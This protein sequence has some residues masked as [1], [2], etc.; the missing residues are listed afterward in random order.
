[1]LLISHLFASKLMAIYLYNEFDEE[2]IIVA[3]ALGGLLPDL[4]DKPLGFLVLSGS[5]NY[6][7]IYFHGILAVLFIF[8]LS[9]ALIRSKYSRYG[10][11]TMGLGFGVLLHQIMDQMWN[12][13]RNWLYPFLGPYEFHHYPDFFEQSL[14]SELASPSEWLFLII[15]GAILI[16]LFRNR[17]KWINSLWTV[18]MGKLADTVL[19]WSPLVLL[20]LGIVLT[21]FSIVGGPLS[22]IYEGR[23]MLAVSA[24]CFVGS[25]IL[26]FR[27]PKPLPAK[28]DE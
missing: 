6:G 2:K 17:W 12:E 9:L 20:M 5:V 8:I 28:P 14:L 18:D 10:T 15:S 21:I 25:A 1:M 23:S 22:S 26:H 16:A 3:T 19:K 4:I 11:I 7:R 27:R 13:P 24:L